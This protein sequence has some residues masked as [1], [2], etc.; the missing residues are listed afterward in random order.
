MI[1]G[2]ILAF[3]PDLDVFFEPL[4]RIKKIEI[5]AHKGWS[6]SFFGALII[7]L[8][9]ALPVSLLFSKPFLNLWAIGFIFYSLHV[10]LDF[11]AASKIPIFYPLTTKRFRFF[12]ER[13]V[14]I[15]LSFISGGFL[16]FFLVTIFS[17]NISIFALFYPY[18]FAFYSIY[19]LYRI[20]SKIWIQWRLPEGS[21]YIPGIL[22][23]V[24]YIYTN[25]EEN[26]SMEYNIIKK[27]QFREEEKPLISSNITLDSEE[28]KLFQKAKELSK[29]FLFFLKWDAIVPVVR[30]NIHETSIKLILGEGLT[31]NRSYVIEIVLDNKT[32]KVLG[33]QDSFV[34]IKQVQ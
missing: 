17:G 2:S 20:L 11:L 31:N 5:L 33:M 6:H 28:W 9:F 7:S 24:Y 13:A 10:V 22:P 12:I 8:L 32:E 19:F 23:F 1:Y 18:M 4:Q 25:K 3:L 27:T 30:N 29:N 34:S 16:V 26:N 14:N 21:T 15:F